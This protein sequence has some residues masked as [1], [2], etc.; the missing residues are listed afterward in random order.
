[1]N[2][3]LPKNLCSFLLLLT[4][5]MAILLA[6]GCSVKSSREVLSPEE[7][8]TR[9]QTLF[10]RERYYRAQQLLEDIVLNYSGSAMIDSAQFLLARSS[11]EQNDFLI[12]ADEF[13]RVITQY[14]YSKLAGDAAFYQA[15][16]YYEISPSYA[17]EQGYTVQAFDA[18]QRY[19]EDYPDHWLADSAYYY[20]AECRE[21][22]AKKEYAA[23]R[24]YYQMGE[25]ASAVFYSNLILTDYYDTSWAGPA[26]FVRARCY[27]ELKNWRKAYE[28]FDLFLEKYPGDR[29][30]ERARRLHALAMKRLQTENGETKAP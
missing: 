10:E 13:N 12:A 21:K 16:S 27:Y 4:S 19:L 1:M 2:R 18:L 29:R 20:I 9:A 8:W 17:L 3:T 30:V 11:F 26:Q 24:L 25:F 14:P 28:E 22:L 7:S 5:V 15:L 6:A 23:A